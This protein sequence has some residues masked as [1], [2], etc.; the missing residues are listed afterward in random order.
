[1]LPDEI[2]SEILSPALKVSDKLFSDTSDVSPFAKYSVSS[3]AYL[4]V[5]KDWLR[6]ATP[7]LY[8]VVVL[9]SKSQANALEKVFETNPEFGL[10]IKKLRIEGGYGP[11]MLTILKACPNVKDLFISFSIWASDSTAGLCKGLPLLNPK[12]VILHD[13]QSDTRSLKNKHLDALIKTFNSCIKSWD[14]LEIFSFPYGSGMR[15]R[16]SW[17]ERVNTLVES[18]HSSSVRTVQLT[19]GIWNPLPVFLRSLS[20]I[21]SLESIELKELLHPN[22]VPFIDAY[23]NLKALARYT[24]RKNPYLQELVPTDAGRHT[25][26]DI[27]PSLNPAFIPM[28]SASEEIRKFIWQRVLFFAMHVQDRRDSS[29]AIPA[30]FSPLSI[31]RVSK[32]FNDLALPY[33]YDLLRITVRNAPLIAAQLE[34]RPEL[35]T[36]IRTI[37]MPERTVPQ[38]A[39]RTIVSCASKLRFFL[40]STSENMMGD[41]MDLGVFTALASTAGSTLEEL[42]GLDV[43]VKV[44]D[45]EWP[46]NADGL[47]SLHTIRTRSIGGQSCILNVLMR[48]RLDALR[49]LIMAEYTSSIIPLLDF[50]EV[51]GGKLSHLTVQRCN[52][53]SIGKPT[54]IDYCPNLIELEF[55]GEY[56]ARQV[57][58]RVKHKSLTKIVAS[59]LPSTMTEL[60]THMLPALQEIQLRKFRWPTNEH[61]IDKSKCVAIAE[62]LLAERGIKMADSKGRYWAPRIKST[63][64]RNT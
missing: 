59:A 14:S 48:F 61:G 25:T 30:H 36:H 60:Q 34:R 52:L 43:T 3:S 9:R 32:L 29:W 26:P 15:F 64:G 53:E 5:C 57:T 51:H 22:V 6:V 2:I 42:R 50:I 38:K 62:A 41:G 55:H 8:H 40:P 18:L 11:A 19:S 1:M 45:S 49:T 31:L 39:M 12:R 13:P 10:F 7:L 58:P 16:S 4:L 23:P 44:D 54:I 46:S 27:A 63:R 33:L 56:D 21:P 47:N 37:F 35:G 28:S 24:L 20:D 17:I